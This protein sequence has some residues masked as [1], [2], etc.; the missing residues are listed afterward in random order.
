MSTW[1]L[2][3]E[4]ERWTDEQTNRQTD[5]WMDRW[6]DGWTGKMQ[7]MGLGVQNQSHEPTTKIGDGRPKEKMDWRK[8]N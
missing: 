4:R 1:R 7:W 8:E 3:R 6:M 5:R 2:R